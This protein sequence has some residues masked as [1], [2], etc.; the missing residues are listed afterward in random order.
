MED[1]G[2]AVGE[3]LSR[4]AILLTPDQVEHLTHGGLFALGTDLL[5]DLVV[6]CATGELRVAKRRC[7]SRCLNLGV[8]PLLDVLPHIRDTVLPDHELGADDER[9]GGRRSVD[10]TELLE[11]LGLEWV[12]TQEPPTLIPVRVSQV[13][14][15][16]KVR[17]GAGADEVL[18]HPFFGSAALRNKLKDF[19]TLVEGRLHGR[20]LSP[21]M[22]DL[23]R[24][25]IPRDAGVQRAVGLGY[26]F[27]PTNMSTKQ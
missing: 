22:A 3:Q 7:R 17:K 10:R 15:P 25:L 26:C 9:V 14:H 19:S 1:V 18:L 24:R 20:V 12:E 27:L 5:A 8:E 4:L 23:W 16:E 6:E 2:T 11:E 21:P 13:V